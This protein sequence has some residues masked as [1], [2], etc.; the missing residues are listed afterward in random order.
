MQGIGAI[1]MEGTSNFL[2]DTSISKKTE[3]L[4]NFILTCHSLVFVIIFFYF[5]ESFRFS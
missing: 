5:M 3:N 2:L 1:D 4:H